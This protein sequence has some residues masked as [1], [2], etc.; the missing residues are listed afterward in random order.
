MQSAVMKMAASRGG[1]LSFIVE[2]GN[3]ND[4]DVLR[5]FNEERLSPRHLRVETV[6]RYFVD[7]ADK[8]SSIALQMADLLAFYARR[9]AM[10]CEKAREYIQV[11]DLEKIMLRAIPTAA[12][13]SF[14][15][16]T[17]EEIAAG[18]VDPQR[19][20]KPSPWL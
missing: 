18:E 12:D 14:E 17:N 8:T 13:L 16:L 7:Y 20:R 2:A 11:S 4:Q 19:W 6:F 5:I 1:T 10:K 15:F 9:H 3:K